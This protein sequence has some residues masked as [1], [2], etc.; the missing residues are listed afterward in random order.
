M[1]TYHRP[2]Y[3]PW[4]LPFLDGG[5]Q[6]DECHHLLGQADTLGRYEG[7]AFRILG[8]KCPRCNHMVRC[9]SNLFQFDWELLMAGI[10]SR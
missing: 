10:V 7:L 3:F 5:W 8:Y 6:C 9:E 1:S 2:I 4:A